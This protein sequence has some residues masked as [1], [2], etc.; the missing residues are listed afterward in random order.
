MVSV[1][2]ARVASRRPLPW[3]PRHHVRVGCEVELQL[4][5]TSRLTRHQRTAGA[6]DT[7]VHETG[8]RPMEHADETRRAASINA[9]LDHRPLRRFLASAVTSILALRSWERPAPRRLTGTSTNLE[10]QSW[11]AHRV[12]GF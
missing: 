6:P 12:G 7:A 2:S 9:G 3:Q 8:S 11:P 10:S 1:A 5:T 4:A